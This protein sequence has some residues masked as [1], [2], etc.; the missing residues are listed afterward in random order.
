MVNKIQNKKLIFG[1]N[2]IKNKKNFYFRVSG[3]MMAAV[4]TFD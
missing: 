3:S 1:V 4:C 2:K